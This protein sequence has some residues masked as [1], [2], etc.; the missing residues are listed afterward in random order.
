MDYQTNG[1][2]YGTNGY[3]SVTQTV[4]GNGEKKFCIRCGSE[5]NASAKFCIRCGAS[6]DNTPYQENNVPNYNEYGMPQPQAQANVASGNKRMLLLGGVIIIVIIVAI[7]AIV[8]ATSS[9]VDK[10][11]VGKWRCSTDKTVGTIEFKKNGKFIA[12]EGSDV[13]SR[14]TYRTDDGVIYCT[15]TYYAGEAISTLEQPVDEYN[16]RVVDSNTIEIEKEYITSMWERK[17]KWVEY[18]RV[19]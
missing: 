17:T 8:S 7:I 16:Y 11:I 3:N 12:D 2:E 10:R 13:E 5:N 9:N 4:G 19:E 15:F 1:Q 6:M 18:W 14:G